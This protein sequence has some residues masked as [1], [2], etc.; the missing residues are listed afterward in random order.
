MYS[1]KWVEENLGISKKA[2][3]YYEDQKLI[4]KT[5][6]NPLNNYREYDERDLNRI[7]AIKTLMKIGYT[8][9][10]IRKLICNNC[11]DFY[12]TLSDKVDRL[13]KQCVENQRCYEFSKTIMLTGRI[14]TTNNLGSINF[15][16]FI[17][18][19]SENFNFSKYK[20][21]TDSLYIGEKLNLA[22]VSVLS[23]S[24][25]EKLYELTRQG[26]LYAIHS[27]LKV[28]AELTSLKYTDT[29]VQK[30][31]GLIYDEFC[32]ILEECLDS[33][34]TKSQFASHMIT[35]FYDDADIAK[36]NKAMYG[37]KAC[38]FI[39]NAIE[40]FGKY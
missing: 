7:W 19:A 28:L 5:S 12:T 16:D 24:D 10:E 40:Y 38:D 36:S 21:M 22:D 37:E 29:A 25:I 6:R 9:K 23:D 18:Y 2:I 39:V 15:E 11:N 1:M 13:E 20:M 31:V 3:R 17:N 8:A 30:V 27:Y 32:V 26:Q 35:N 34:I 4:P 33:N 14:P